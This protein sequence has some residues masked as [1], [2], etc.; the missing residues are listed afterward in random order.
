MCKCSFGKILAVAEITIS[1]PSAQ[2]I[3]SGGWWKGKITSKRFFQLGFVWFL[4][5]VQKVTRMILSPLVGVLWPGHHLVLQTVVWWEKRLI[6]HP[7][8]VHHKIVQKKIP[9]TP[10]GLLFKGVTDANNHE[11]QVS[12]DVKVSLP[13]GPASLDKVL[14]HFFSGDWCGGLAVRYTLMP[15]QT[16]SH[17]YPSSQKLLSFSLWNSIQGIKTKTK[18]DTHNKQN[19][20]IPPSPVS[21]GSKFQH[22]EVKN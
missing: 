3:L 5:W 10:Q 11:G 8:V 4:L 22:C 17:R 13:A 2:M 6:V 1:S 19:T 15:K 7:K 12:A 18:S 14:N 21:Q 16:E 20:T 9:K